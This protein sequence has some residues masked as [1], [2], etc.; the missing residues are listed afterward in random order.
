VAR[1]SPPCYVIDGY[2]RAVIL[3]QEGAIFR[4]VAINWC[5]PRAA[6]SARLECALPS[7]S[8]VEQKRIVCRSSQSVAGKQRSRDGTQWIQRGE[9]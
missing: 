3:G 1:K 9:T 4:D 5:W 8:A 2:H 6:S 7:T